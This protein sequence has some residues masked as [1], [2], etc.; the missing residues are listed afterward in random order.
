MQIYLVNYPHDHGAHRPP[1]L[2]A[3]HLSRAVALVQHQYPVAYSCLDHVHGDIVFRRR[4]AGE[5]EPLDQE[6]LVAV[7]DRVFDGGNDRTGVA[8]TVP[9]T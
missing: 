9:A 4:P 6:E 3:Q 5:V 1:R 7:E 2:Y 8:T